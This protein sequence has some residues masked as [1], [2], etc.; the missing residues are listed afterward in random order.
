MG[1]NKKRRIIILEI[2][3]DNLNSNKAKLECRACYCDSV[4]NG[5]PCGWIDKLN[6]VCREIIKKDIEYT[7]ENC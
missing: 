1:A 2:L 5:L 3:N 4:L 7:I 6:C